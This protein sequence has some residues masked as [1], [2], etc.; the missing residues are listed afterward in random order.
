MVLSNISARSYPINLILAVPGVGRLVLF[1]AYPSKEVIYHEIWGREVFLFDDRNRPV[2]QIDPEPGATDSIHRNFD[3]ARPATE[4]FSTIN[5][6]DERFYA[7]RIGGDTFLIDMA[8]GAAS[9]IGWA[10]T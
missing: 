1:E 6:N 10:R 4:T 9:Y 2:W 5:H 8:T 3:A 7:S